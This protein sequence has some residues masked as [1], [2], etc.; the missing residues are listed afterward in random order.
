M[1]L[2]VTPRKISFALGN[3]EPFYGVLA[4]YDMAKKVKISE[5][6]YFDVN[7]DDVSSSFSSLPRSLPYGRWQPMADACG[8]GLRCPS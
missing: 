7:D 6:F 5:N 2:L 3:F 4:L 1:Q 8:G